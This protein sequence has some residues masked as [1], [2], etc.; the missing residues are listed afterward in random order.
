MK[1]QR[2]ELALERLKPGDWPRFERF[3]S[4]FL[5]FDYGQLRSV[6]T[7]SGDLGRD[8]ELFSPENDGAVLMQYSVATNWTVKIKQT[9]ERIRENF[10]KTAILIYVTNQQI[11]AKGDALK[12]EIRTNF[13]LALDIHD[14]A[15]F[16]DRLFSPADR[17]KVAESLAKDVVDPFLSSRD[18]VDSSSPA[19]SEFESKAAVL[20]LQLQ[21]ED[22]SREKGLTK[23]C[24][25]GL[26][27]SVLRETSSEKRLKTQ[28]VRVA[29]RKLLPNIAPETVDLYVNSALERLDKKS[30]KHWREEDEVC[31]SHDEVLRVR[32]G[33]ANKEIKDS[34]LVCEIRE[35]IK[36]YFDESP[37]SSVLE[38]LSLRARRI[39]DQ[40][41]FKKGEEFA[42]AVAN[43]RC[44][45]ISGDALD[46]IVSN[47]FTA[48]KDRTG[49]GENAVRAVRLAVVEI[50]QRSGP[51]VHRYLREIADGYTLLGFLRAV[52]DVQKV[53][54]KIFSEGEI[55]IDTSVLLPVLAETLL[56]ENEQ[57]ASR[58]LRTAKDVGLKLRV[59]SGVVEEVERHINRCKAYTRIA[60]GQWIGGV[61][62]LYAMYAIGGHKEDGFQTWINNFCGDQRPQDDVA[63]YLSDEWGVEISDMNDLVQATPDKL[64]WEVER[65]W[66][67]AHEQRRRMGNLEIDSFVI[68][69]LASHD[70][71][72]FLG[73]ISKRESSPN[74]D[75]GYTHWWLTFDKTVRDFEQK[76]RE[77]LGG[78]APE[79][80]V[81]SP[82]FLADYLAIGPLRARVA[83]EIEANLPLAIFDILADQIPAELIE[84]AGGVRKDCGDLNERLLRR[85]LRDTMDNIKRTPG[86]LAKGGFAEIRAN[87]ERVLK[88]RA[89]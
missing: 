56:N 63:D 76:L 27:K 46:V 21:W 38:E 71:E 28:L 49:L 79:T 54:Q 41:L 73:V 75:L 87:L 31:L 51:Q 29:V 39:L 43:N 3:A 10:P 72:C 24:Y 37:Q 57:I 60:N 78:K 11:G 68:D 36:D 25:E 14:R 89:H 77:S 58:L 61:P 84:V 66:H 40:F 65:I 47:D 20:H 85:R 32:E 19:L 88:S 67:E 69:R 42:A 26:V 9:A 70:V 44:I 5:V 18:V 48:N 59:T 62:F 53:V 45:T 6:A 33:F 13:K 80:P 86:A 74:S 22:D 30:V 23:L 81:M 52:P 4:Q 15:W 82:D 1:T 2:F 55:W 12:K 50:L 83:K 17:T 16:L 64:R 8:A 7:A 35:T 34:A